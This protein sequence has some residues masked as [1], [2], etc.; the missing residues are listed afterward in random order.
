MILV[1]EVYTM[2]MLPT[3]DNVSRLLT[4][5]CSSHTTS[6]FRTNRTY[7]MSTIPW[8]DRLFARREDRFYATQE[9]QIYV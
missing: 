2:S 1:Y 8:G 9:L 6:R 3:Y 5:L 7:P 4:F